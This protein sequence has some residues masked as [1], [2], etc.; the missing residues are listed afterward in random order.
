MKFHFKQIKKQ[1]TLFMIPAFQ[2][3]MQLIYP[4]NYKNNFA[5]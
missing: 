3:K 2:F 1:E 5:T 4:A